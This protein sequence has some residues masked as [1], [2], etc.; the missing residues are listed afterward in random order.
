LHLS[1]WA[2]PPS[3]PPALGTADVHLWRFPLEAAASEESALVEL[4]SPRERERADGIRMDAQR[5][6]YIIGHGRLRQVLARYVNVAP[7]A[8]EF[9]RHPRGKPFVAATQNVAGMHFNF[10][11]TGNIGLVGVALKRPLGVDVE[12]HRNDMDM[13]LIARRQFAPGEQA[14]LM[15]LPTAQRRAAF[16]E[17]WTRKEAYLKAIGDGIAG[18]LQG[19]EVSFLADETPAILRAKEGPGECAR[20][21]VIPILA[22]AELSAACIVERP[23]ERVTG[24]DLA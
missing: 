3:V 19:F 24:W 4:L 14:R 6:R 7:E 11:H 13:E 8:I 2:S 1:E 21:A 15:S 9:G 17:C 22:G 18:G 16:Y 20:W 23:V 10:S 12:Q 5:R